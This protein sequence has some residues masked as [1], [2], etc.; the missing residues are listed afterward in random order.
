MFLHAAVGV[1]LSLQTSWPLQLTSGVRSEGFCDIQDRSGRARE[2]A[3][4][5]CLFWQLCCAGKHGANLWSCTCCT[6]LVPGYISGS[7]RQAWRLL[8]V[9]AIA[10]PWA[11]E[12]RPLVCP[13]L[14]WAH[15]HGWVIAGMHDPRH[16]GLQTRELSRPLPK[17]HPPSEPPDPSKLQTLES[18][19]RHTVY[20]QAMARPSLALFGSS[21]R[22]CSEVLMV[23]SF[24][25][26]HRI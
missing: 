9:L 12:A 18:M 17:F 26:Q 15:A 2:F 21:C 10:K 11:Q 20:T 6:M 23:G 1:C 24:V 25:S 7:E 13:D 19:F 16:N 5:W 3:R 4:S 8:N 14:R 22:P